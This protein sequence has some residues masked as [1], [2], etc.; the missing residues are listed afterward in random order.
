MFHTLYANMYVYTLCIC[1]CALYIYI[2][3]TDW[4]TKGNYQML[5]VQY[6]L[7]FFYSVGLLGCSGLISY[8]SKPFFITFHWFAPRFLTQAGSFRNTPTKTCDWTTLMSV[9][10]LECTINVRLVTHALVKTT[11]WAKKRGHKLMII[12]L[13]NL[14]R[15]TIFFHWKGP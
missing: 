11:G 10:M 12:I 4:R 8:G 14:N 3:E 1:W 7:R 5:I 15:F 2:C 13:S 6:W 9:W